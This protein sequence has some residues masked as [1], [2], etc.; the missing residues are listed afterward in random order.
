[1]GGFEAAGG[2]LR[3]V[4]E[5]LT[6]PGLGI[7]MSFLAWVFVVS[8]VAKLRR[9]ALTA[10]AIVDFG[11]TRRVVPR[12]GTALGAVE[13]GLAVVLMLRILPAATLALTGALLSAF[14]FVVA[15]ALLQ[16]RS[17]PCYC[18]GDSDGDLSAWTLVRAGALAMLAVLAVVGGAGTV[19]A[20]LQTR[21][22]QEVTAASV[23][24][25][26]LTAARVP[27][28][29]RW[30]GDAVKVLRSTPA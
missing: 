12:L 22:L 16:K 19:E 1:M 15:R 26:A 10:M 6:G 11:V 20:T 7:V 25:T 24:G 13:L 27:R 29:V 9:P 21:A 17:F 23:F 2:L 3:G 28:L 5:Q 14:V 4:Y 18:F 8:G 30:N